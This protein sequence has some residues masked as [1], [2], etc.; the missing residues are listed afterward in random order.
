MV[1]SSI[2]ENIDYISVKMSNVRTS[3]YVF[4]CLRPFWNLGYADV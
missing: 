1:Y 4:T 3:A 2:K